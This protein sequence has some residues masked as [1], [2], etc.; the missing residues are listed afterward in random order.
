MG[1]PKRDNSPE[2]TQVDVY[3]LPRVK[4]SEAACHWARL[5]AGVP[6]CGQH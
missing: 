1:S 2:G 5:P 6:D 3:V 4:G